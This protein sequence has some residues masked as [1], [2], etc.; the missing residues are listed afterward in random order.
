M[1]RITFMS[2]LIVLGSGQ[3]VAQQPAPGATAPVCSF[4]EIYRA[5]GWTV[6]GLARATVKS[7]RARFS[8]IPGV[9]V[10]V[11]MPVESESTITDIWCPPDHEGRLEIKEQPIGIL[12]LWSFDFAGRVFAYGVSYGREAM[13]NGARVPI[14]AA[15]AV[16]FYDVDGSGRFAVRKWARYP[17]MPDFVPDWAKKDAVAPSIR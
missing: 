11:L 10:T 7:Q 5:E 14:G 9:F 6:P 1:F 8:N 12:N 13:Q 2:I 4:S 3:L 16:M 17:F 15:S